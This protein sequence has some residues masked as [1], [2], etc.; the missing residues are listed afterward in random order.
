MDPDALIALAQF[1]LAHEMGPE[2]LGALDLTVQARPRLS[3]DPRVNAMRGA[4]S[5]MMA[6]YDDARRYFTVPQLINDASVQ[7]WL[8]LIA[9]EQSNWA[10]ARRRFAAGEDSFFY[11]S[12]L[13]RARIHA[14]NARASLEAN[15]L[16]AAEL[17]LLEVDEDITDPLVRSEV[18]FIRAR[19][20]QARG[21][22]DQALQLYEALA[23]PGKSAA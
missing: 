2:A 9:V 5:Y 14:A 18:E 23:H 3:N 11:L 16:A 17:G 1:Y 8:G 21:D 10:E 22:A 19:L 7:N 15:D 20:I 12:P 13:W 4:A 6:R